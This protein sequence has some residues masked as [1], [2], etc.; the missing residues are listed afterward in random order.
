MRGREDVRVA[1]DEEEA[2]AGT[3]GAR[4]GKEEGRSEQ[5]GGSEERGGR[6][7]QR[8]KEEGHSRKR[9]RKITRPK[10]V[11]G[12]YKEEHGRNRCERPSWRT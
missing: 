3:E 9:G 4:R 6:D 2:K 7:V 12:R 1:E 5:M 11:R 8:S 10:Y